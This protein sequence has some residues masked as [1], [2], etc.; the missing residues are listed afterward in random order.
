MDR[1]TLITIRRLTDISPELGRSMAPLFDD[2]VAWDVAEG[3]RFLTNPDCLFLLAEAGTVPC[4]F[5]TAYRLQRF[6][7]RRAEVLLYEVGVDDAFRRRGAAAALIAELNRWCVEVGATEMW[8]LTE[9]GNVAANALYA[10]TGGEPDPDTVQMYT[11]S[12]DQLE[13]DTPS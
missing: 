4:G 8:V 9:T 1:S 3:E 11:Y 12:L 5:L 6:D 10:A 13:R 2:D 7:A